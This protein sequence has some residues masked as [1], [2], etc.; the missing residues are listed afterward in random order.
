[1]AAQ[2]SREDLKIKSVNCGVFLTTGNLFLFTWFIFTRIVLTG[3]ISSYH[4]RKSPKE[5]LQ[6]RSSEGTNAADKFQASNRVT[7]WKHLSF[8][9]QW[10][11]QNFLEWS[12]QKSLKLHA[13]RSKSNAIRRVI[14]LLFEGK[15]GTEN[16]SQ[17]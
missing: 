11:F 6:T 1:M 9:S 5:N 15:I 2:I 7:R 3:N 16:K 13:L 8:T 4:E 10:V 17:V 14:T 12:M